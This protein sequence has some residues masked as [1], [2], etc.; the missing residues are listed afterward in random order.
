[1]KRALFIFIVSML[2][3]SCRQSN[4]ENYVVA[5]VNHEKL[6]IEDMKA[7]FTENQWEE[8]SKKAKEQFVQDWIKLA[9]LAQEADNLGISY[10][11]Q[12]KNKIITAEKNIKANA[13]IAQKMAEI[14]VSEDDLF[15]YYRVHKSQFQKSHKEYAVQRIFITDEAKLDEVKTAINETSFKDAAIKYS[16]ENIGKAGG[17]LGFVSQQKIN[18][19][20][21]NALT[22]L[23]IYR[24]Q[25]VQADGGFYVIRFYDEKTVSTDKTF[26]EVI[27]N[28]RATLLKQKQQETYE[29]LIEELKKKSEVEISL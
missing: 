17:Y 26:V 10:T 7:N 28:I 18:S 2:V 27:E 5:R 13:L 22:Q 6:F 8:L 21:W 12:I 23:K 16:Q 19:E 11:P 9:I 14:K 29:N 1:M 24:W 25:T 3:F 20:L 4:E 15:N